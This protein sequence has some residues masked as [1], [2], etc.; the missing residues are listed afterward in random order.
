MI[1][2][3]AAG[4]V[5]FGGGVALYIWLRRW[6]HEKDKTNNGPEEHR[7][8]IPHARQLARI[9]TKTWEQISGLPILKPPFFVPL[10][11]LEACGSFPRCG[12]NPK[13]VHELTG[14]TNANLQ[15]PA[16][17]F[18]ATRTAFVFCS[19]R[20]IRP[21]DSNR[22]HPDDATNS[23]YEIVLAALRALQRGPSS[24]VPHHFEVAVWVDFC[25]IE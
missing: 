7:G 14:L 17:S 19:H 9:A 24:P 15:R 3:A 2:R 16:N 11:D 18:D 21:G 23:K 22:G 13:F 6:W 4:F 8:V 10:A 5:A 12:S 20:W 1:A 25:C